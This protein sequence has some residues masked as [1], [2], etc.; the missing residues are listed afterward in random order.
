MNAIVS[1][2][3]A[4]SVLVHAALGCCAHHA[5]GGLVGCCSQRTVEPEPEAVH[6]HCCKH[7][8]PAAS[9]E[10]VADHDQ[11]E[12][13]PAPHKTCDEGRCNAVLAS[14]T[15][16]SN[17]TLAAATSPC[18]A[19]RGIAI[20]TVNPVVTADYASLQHDLGPPLRA[21]LCYCVLLV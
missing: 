3:T 8:H 16:H 4:A 12:P 7:K 6:H 14:K 20:T 15:S 10:L 18:V 5:H 9:Q 1:I 19:C 21:H 11:T 17:V 2:V 13:T